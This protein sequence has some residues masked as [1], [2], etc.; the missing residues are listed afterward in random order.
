[1]SRFN[2]RQ[3][4][5]IG[6]KRGRKNKGILAGYREQKRHEAEARQANVDPRRT[7]AFRLGSSFDPTTGKRRRWTSADWKRHDEAVAALLQ[8][9]VAE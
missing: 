3:D 6:P 5:F 4:F 9:G 7:K 1:M 8:K 2:G